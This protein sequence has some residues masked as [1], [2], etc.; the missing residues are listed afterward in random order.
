MTPLLP[1]GNFP[2]GKIVTLG[3]DVWIFTQVE[4]PPP[5]IST[6]PCLGRPLRDLGSDDTVVNRISAVGRSAFKD[7]LNSDF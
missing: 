1:V 2:V 3:P 4:I 7:W 5:C 6:L